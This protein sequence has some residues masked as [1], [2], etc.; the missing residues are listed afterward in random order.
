MGKTTPPF[1]D[2]NNPLTIL[3]QCHICMKC[4]IGLNWVNKLDMKTHPF[5]IM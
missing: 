2:L 3:V 5:Y 4:D 1:A